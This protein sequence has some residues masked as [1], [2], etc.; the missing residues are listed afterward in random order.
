[1]KSSVPKSRL[2]RDA[3]RNWRVAA[4]I[5]G[6]IGASLATA[7]AQAA[8]CDPV[9][10]A[11]GLCS[12]DEEAQTREAYAAM[13]AR[14]L[15]DMPLLISQSVSSRP[16]RPAPRLAQG[17]AALKGMAAGDVAPR[18]NAWAS[19]ARANL[20][21]SFQP[22]RSSGHG[23]M[24][25]AG[26]DYTF[27]NDLIAGVAVSA[28]ATRIST[29]F[30]SGGVSGDG[31]TVAPYLALPLGRAWLLDASA[32]W[33]RTAMRS[34]DNS[35][36]AITGQM[37]DR[38][39]FTAVSLSYGTEIGAWQMQGK[40]SYL[41][42][43]DRFG[44]TTLSSGGTVAGTKAHLS[45][46]RLGGQATYDAGTIAPFVGVHY[47]TDVA[48]SAQAAVAGQNPSNDRDSI[49]LQLGINLYS[50][51]GMSGG[52]VYSNEAGRSQIKNDSIMANIAFRF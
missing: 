52:L 41:T 32:G 34:I 39:F 26:L 13:S 44:Q 48:R 47:I 24:A 12:S 28:E 16:G 29:N 2:D 35:G 31:T 36:A 14:W 3:R 6:T 17:E 5:M 20:G 19:A 51:N 49:Q 7:P 1:M 46:I 10:L 45:Q 22:L 18:W 21:Y 23:D 30:N 37:T 38:R 33:G 27:A 42:S 40:G 50:K 43:E 15:A 11:L 4:S 8:F 9:M 25:L